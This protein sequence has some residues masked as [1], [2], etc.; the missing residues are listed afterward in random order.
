LLR[1]WRGL[2]TGRGLRGGVKVRGRG[3]IKPKEWIAMRSGCQQLE[4]LKNWAVR[5]LGVCVMAV[6]SFYLSNGRIK[7]L[8]GKKKKKKGK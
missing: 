7:R 3:R 5:L 8:G 1:L 2:E 6:C 4:D